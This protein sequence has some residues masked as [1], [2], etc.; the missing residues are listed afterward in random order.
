MEQVLRAGTS[1]ILEVDGG[2]GIWYN[3]T[4]TFHGHQWLLVDKQEGVHAGGR[5]EFT[6]V[7][8]FEVFSDYQKGN[9]KDR[10]SVRNVQLIFKLNSNCKI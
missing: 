4:F 5:A 8:T 9:L 10:F 2:E 7:K 6:G 3:E 1:A